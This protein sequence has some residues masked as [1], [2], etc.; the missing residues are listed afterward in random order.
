MYNHKRNRVLTGYSR[1]NRKNQTETEKL[2]WFRL[3][4]RQLGGYKFSRQYA[5]ADYI[6]DFY[7][8][9]KNLAIE[10]DGSQH[11]EQLEYDLKR[12]QYLQS[13]GITVIRF[14]DNEVFKNIEGV[15]ASILEKIN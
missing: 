14:W 8:V 12:T 13:L 5:L 6:L 9:E 1:T 2:L 7:C 11:G 10:L 4:S 3:R 15:L